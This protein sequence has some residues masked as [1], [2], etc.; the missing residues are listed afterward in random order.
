MTD[1]VDSEEFAAT[2]RGLAG[3]Y[4]DRLDDGERRF[5]ASAAGAGEWVE[6]LEQLAAG[7]G[8]QSAAIT[9]EERKELVELFRASGADLTVLDGV[10]VRS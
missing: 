3:H 2:M 9:A 10:T 8:R 1:R 5:V 7:L 4:G 6:A